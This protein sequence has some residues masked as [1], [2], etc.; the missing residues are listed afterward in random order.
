MAD[1]NNLVPKLKT[2]MNKFLVECKKQGIDL[3]VTQGFRS[4]LEQNALYAQGR[5]MPGKIVTNAK[6][7]QSAHN[8]GKAFDICFLVNKKASYVGDWVKVGAIGELCGLTWG[9]RWKS[10]PDKPHFEIK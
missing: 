5:T 8:F 7:G 2:L 3:I 6:G 1:V 10:F 4:T 9:G